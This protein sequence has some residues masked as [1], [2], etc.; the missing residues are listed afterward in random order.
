MLTRLQAPAI[1]DGG[2]P[3]L[4]STNYG[5]LRA[6]NRRDTGHTSMAWLEIPGEQTMLGPQQSGEVLVVKLSG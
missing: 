5:I 4:L 6:K 3:G 1:M 2:L